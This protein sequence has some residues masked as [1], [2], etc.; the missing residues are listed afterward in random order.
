NSASLKFIPKS[1]LA[2]AGYSEYEKLFA[3]TNKKHTSNLEEAM[4]G[5]GCFWGVEELIRKLP[6]IVATEVGYAGGKLDHPSY[7]DVKKGNSGHA[8]VIHLKFDPSKISYKEIMNYFFRIHDPTTK[9][10]QGNDRGTQYRSVIFAKDDQQAQI[11]KEAI[12][13]AA[14]S[15]RWKNPIVTEIVSWRSF[16]RAEEYH[17]RYLEQNPGGYT[18]HFLRK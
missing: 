1:K 13:N 9:D 14:K 2:T 17:Q 16:Y 4:F 6:G 11:A 18:C 7:N 12:A 15:G 5:G 8:E 3:T 10:Q